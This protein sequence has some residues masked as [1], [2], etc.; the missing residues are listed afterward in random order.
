M[1]PDEPS[2]ADKEFFLNFQIHVSFSYFSTWEL[3]YFKKTASYSESTV[4]IYFRATFLHKFVRYLTSL[5]R[6][7][8]LGYE[9]ECVKNML[10]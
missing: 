1:I 6:K 5:D 10:R 4:Q 2:L 3:G 8:I 9:R 7:V